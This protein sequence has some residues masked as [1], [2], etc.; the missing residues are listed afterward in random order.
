MN[1][2]QCQ[3]H[4]FMKLSFHSITPLQYVVLRH[5]DIT[6]TFGNIS[7]FYGKFHDNYVNSEGQVAQLTCEVSGTCKPTNRLPYFDDLRVSLLI[8]TN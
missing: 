6:F 1:P 3:D 5:R 4:G 7:S 2:M 8:T